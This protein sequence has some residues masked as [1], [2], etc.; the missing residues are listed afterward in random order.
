VCRETA[1]LAIYSYVSPVDVALPAI[2]QVERRPVGPGSPSSTGDGWPEFR[3]VPMRPATHELEVRWFL[4]QAPVVTAAEGDAASA[5]EEE[6][7]GLTPLERR[8]R[9]RLKRREGAAPPAAGDVGLPA[10]FPFRPDVR[11]R[12]AGTA[13]EPLPKGK[14]LK[15][16]DVKHEGGGEASVPTL[17][18]LAPGRYL[19][20]AVVRDRAV[21]KGERFAWVLKDDRGLLED[22]VTWTL[23]VPDGR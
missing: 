19:L 20:T 21:F 8:L 16:K 3:V 14:E 15:A 17:P 9:D 23:V 6:P 2:G 10:P 13:K 7:E 12:H 18:P 22:R 1:V 11:R 4:D 5:T